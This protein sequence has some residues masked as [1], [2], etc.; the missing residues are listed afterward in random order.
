MGESARLLEDLLGSDAYIQVNKKLIKELGLHEAIMIAELLSERKY[1]YMHDKL[2]DDCWFYSTRENLEENTGLSPYYQREAILSLVNAEVLETKKM[3]LPAK[4]YYRVVDDKLLKALTACKETVSRQDEE[5]FNDINNNKR[6][7][8]KNN[9]KI[10]S[11]ETGALA[12]HPRNFTKEKLRDDLAS[13]KDIDEQKKEKKKTTE[14]DKCLKLLD[15]RYA[16]HKLYT[17]LI[18]HLDWSY[19]SADPKRIRSVKTYSK[20]LD[21]FD[22][23]TGDKIKI[24][25]QSIDRQWH[26][27]YELQKSENKSYTSHSDSHIKGQTLSREDAKKKLAEYAERN[28]VV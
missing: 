18:Q 1:W 28:G 17:I 25:Q 24:V 9:N 8:I 10:K 6:I 19:N 26:C 12:K 23:L 2:T 22:K 7:T 11:T 13:G 27:F 20:R 21:E 16:D 15:E 3:G 14:Y 4:V 5:P